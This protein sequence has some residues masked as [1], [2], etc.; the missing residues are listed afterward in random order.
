LARNDDYSPGDGRRPY[1]DEGG[2]EGHHA[3][4][5]DTRREEA[6][7][8]RAED[9]GGEDFEADLHADRA[10]SHDDE[11]ILAAD[12]KE[13]RAAHPELSADELKRLSILTVGTRLDQGSTYVD[14]D[15]LEAGP[16]TA[17]GS[18][19]AGPDVRLVAK[20][21]TDHELWDRLVGHPRT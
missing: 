15:A 2:S 18:Q 17:M 3:R 10:A 14:L 1:S 20:R 5:H 9:T 16:F 13:V 7:R 19:E 8:A 12:D 21:D 6:T 11:S 4:S